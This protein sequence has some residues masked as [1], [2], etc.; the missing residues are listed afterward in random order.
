MFQE[1]KQ[2]YGLNISHTESHSEYMIFPRLAALSETVWSPKDKR[3]WNDFS[4]RVQVMFQRFDIMGINYAKS[5]YQVSAELTS[6][7]TSPKVIMDL[8]NEFPGGDIRYVLNDGIFPSE[9]KVVYSSS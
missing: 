3:N 7:V 8:K 2:I 1:G 4:R 5:A 9:S 6:E